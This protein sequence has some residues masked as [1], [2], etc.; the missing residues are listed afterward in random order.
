MAEPAWVRVQR[1]TFTR[2]CNNYLIQR[3]IA[4][5]SLEKDIADGVALHSLLEILSGE[6]INPQP[7]KTSE[8]KITE[9]REH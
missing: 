4:L 6:T 7:K 1:K 3:N 8:T 5:D 2:W 9:S